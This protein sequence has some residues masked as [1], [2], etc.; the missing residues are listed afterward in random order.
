MGCMVK[1]AGRKHTYLVCMFS[2]E[3]GWVAIHCAVARDWKRSNQVLICSS[4]LV[5]ELK[6]VGNERD[7][8]EEIKSVA[9]SC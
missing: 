8:R 3:V 2:I 4:H 6:Q 9:G 7:H 5:S 1:H